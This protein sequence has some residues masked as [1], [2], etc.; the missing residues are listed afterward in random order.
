MGCGPSKPDLVIVQHE[1]GMSEKEAKESFNGF[2]KQTG[3]SKIKLDKFTKF[4]SS[5]NTNKGKCLVNNVYCLCNF[6]FNIHM[7]YVGRYVC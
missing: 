3:S 5:L 4:V 6:S 1:L 2:K 7:Y